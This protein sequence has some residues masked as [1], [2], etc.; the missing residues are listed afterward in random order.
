M[1][2]TI[3]SSGLSPI[4]PTTAI[5]LLS[6]VPTLCLITRSSGGLP[7]LSSVLFL[8]NR[9]K[10]YQESAPAE[11]H[12]PSLQPYV[13]WLQQVL[14]QLYSV[15]MTFRHIEFVVRDLQRIWLYLWATLDYMEIYKPRMD[16]LAPPSQGVA[17]TI[18]MFTY[19]IRVAQDMFVAGLPC[20]LIRL[21][22][23]FADEKIFQ[24]SEIFHPKDY[25][26]LDGHRFNYPVIF[27]G[28]A[29]SLNKYYSIEVFAHNFLCS[30]DPFATTST[31]LSS[32]TLSGSSTLSTPAVASSSASRQSTGRDFRGVVRTPAKGRG[33]GKLSLFYIFGIYYIKLLL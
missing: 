10:R 2:T 4:L 6:P 5:S 14:D 8:F 24:I 19:N 15:H 17:D 11:Q 27:Q 28:P 1:A 26:T 13:K 33:A 12:P 20:W 30:Q 23:G 32:T 3:P 16:G 9:V 7:F 29:T 25:I 18:G 22:N 21:S 31:P